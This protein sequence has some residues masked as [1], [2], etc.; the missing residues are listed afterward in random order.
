VLEERAELSE[1]PLR[2]LGLT[3]RQA[4][5]L[6]WGAQGKTNPEIGIILGV[7]ADTVHKHLEQV[8]AKLHVETRTAAA[9]RANEL[10][11]EPADTR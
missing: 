10:L 11:N 3:P 7:S 8:F 5:V 6:L 9:W 1:A 2:R 4:A